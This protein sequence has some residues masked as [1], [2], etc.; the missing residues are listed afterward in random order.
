MVTNNEEHNGNSNEIVPDQE[1]SNANDV[2]LDSGD[3][4][5]LV[6][7]TPP[8][9]PDPLFGFD[10]DNY[11]KGVSGDERLRVL[12]LYLGYLCNTD[13]KYDQL[14]IQLK[15]VLWDSK[16]SPPLGVYAIRDYIK[17]NDARWLRYHHLRQY[18][19]NR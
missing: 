19:I 9:A 8:T 17:A 15:L 7:P 6:P 14:K 18:P 1:P 4:N 16:N 12:D 5:P 2:P 11:K 3:S 13:I 10:P